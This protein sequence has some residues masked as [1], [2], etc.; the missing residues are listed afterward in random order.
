MD[1]ILDAGAILLG[2]QVVM[3]YN[4]SLGAIR[5]PHLWVVQNVSSCY[6]DSLYDVFR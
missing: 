6:P 5:P 3:A 2:I 4:Q 1:D